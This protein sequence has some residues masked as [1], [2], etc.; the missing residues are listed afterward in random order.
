MK[1]VIVLLMFVLIG[2]SIFNGCNLNKD[3]FK[4]ESGSNVVSNNEVIVNGKYDDKDNVKVVDDDDLS[5]YIVGTFNDFSHNRGLLLK[6]NNNVDKSRTIKL[7]NAVVDG[8]EFEAM[9]SKEKIGPHGDEI[10]TV[11]FKNNKNFETARGE[12][13]V[14]DSESGKELGEYNFNIRI[15]KK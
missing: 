7:K 10:G 5:I 9:Y 14:L 12:V 8:K 15:V 3:T 2:G 11:T 4:L 6:V 13:V 1:K